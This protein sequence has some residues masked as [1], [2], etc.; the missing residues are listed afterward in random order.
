MRQLALL[1][2][3]GCTLT[4]RAQDFQLR[5]STG[6]TTGPYRVRQGEPVK[7]GTNTATIVNVRSQQNRT[8]D[9]MQAIRIPE[10]D[11]RQANLRD[12]VTFLVNASIEY[13]ADNKGVSFILK[14]DDNLDDVEQN[15][16]A[17]FTTPTDDQH[18]DSTPSTPEPT[19]TLSALDIT[20]KELLDYCV[21]IAG[22]KYSIRNGGVI[23]MPRHM[24][25]GP[26]IVRLYNILPSASTRLR[27]LGSGIRE[28]RPNDFISLCGTTAK[29]K[30]DDPDL[31]A[32]FSEMGVEWPTGSYISYIRGMGK[33]TVAN[34]EANLAVFEEMLDMLNVKPYQ[35]EIELAF[36][37]CDRQQITKLGPDGITTASLLELW[38]DGD[39]ELLAAPR[40]LTQSGQSAMIRG[41]TEYIYATDLSYSSSGRANSSNETKTASIVTPS[42][43][44]TREVGVIMEVLPEI[45]PEG[46]LINVSLSPEYVDQPSWKPFKGFMMDERGNTNQIELLQPYFHS[47][48]ETTNVLLSNGERILIGGG[49]PSRDGKQLIF[50]LLGAR[51]IG[52][53]G[54]WLK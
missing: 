11:F 9:A 50:M 28:S 39:A 13:S 27:E 21:D 7:I 44:A 25:D 53:D 45:S 31:K 40:V 30:N 49:L 48:Q 8:L 23:I 22:Y 10:V 5:S 32:F 37:A 20:L 36:L 12:V 51:K 15:E 52:T 14:T 54:E 29:Q 38:T 16:E 24:P 4:I 6:E 33:L 19:I 2:V 43:F 17:P 1:I 41:A 26:I 35:L 18:S 47:Y 3:F 46:N 34:T 42:D